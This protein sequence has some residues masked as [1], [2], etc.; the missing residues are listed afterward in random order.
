MSSNTSLAA[1]ESITNLHKY[2]RGMRQQSAVRMHIE[3]SFDG[4]T[5][6]VFV[7]GCCAVLD[8]SALVRTWDSSA[9]SINHHLSRMST[10][11]KNGAMWRTHTCHDLFGP[12]TTTSPTAHASPHQLKMYACIRNR[13][14]A[15][16]V[17]LLARVTLMRGG[18]IHTSEGYVRMSKPQH[19]YRE[20]YA[21]SI[22][23]GDRTCVGF[24]LFCFFPWVFFFPGTFLI[25]DW[26]RWF[27]D[28]AHAAAHGRMANTTTCKYYC[29]N[30]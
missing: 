15:R 6:R 1:R 11:G 16:R 17:T 14:F 22:Q 12:W 18:T 27:V 28:E 30:T 21:R 5:S 10:S 4:Y 19:L 7:V 8:L 23:N 3:H 29:S 26:W 25:D 13:S 9:A 24:L 20:E 2:C